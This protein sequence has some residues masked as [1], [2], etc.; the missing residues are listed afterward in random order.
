MDDDVMELTGDSK[1]QSEVPKALSDDEIQSIIQSI[2]GDSKLERRHIPSDSAPFF[3]PA[4]K[5]GKDELT[6]VDWRKEEKLFAGIFPDVEALRNEQMK[7][8]SS[9][10]SSSTM[11]IHIV[12]EGVLNVARTA[13]DDKIQ[14]PN[15]ID[16]G[17]GASDCSSLDDASSLQDELMKLCSEIENA[18]GKKASSDDYSSTVDLTY[19]EERHLRNAIDKVRRGSCRWR[20]D[21]SISFYSPPDRK[22]SRLRNVQQVHR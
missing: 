1:R 6:V 3:G 9:S 16:V 5:L 15:Q 11:S 8:K 13:A 14:V 22:E 2:R 18:N 12:D 17:A 7:S 19:Q 4:R 10:G 20:L 21:N